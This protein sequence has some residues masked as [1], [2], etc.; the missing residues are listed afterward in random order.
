MRINNRNVFTYL[1]IGVVG[2]VGS[3]QIP[4]FFEQKHDKLINVILISRH[5]ARTPLH[6][7]QQLNNVYF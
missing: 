6:V 3:F 5:G 4:Y 2:V 1:T 7:T